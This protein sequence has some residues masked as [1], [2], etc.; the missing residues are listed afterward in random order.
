MRIF[1]SYFP[2]VF[3]SY[4]SLYACTAGSTHHS[5]CS[6]RIYAPTPSHPFLTHGLALPPLRTHFAPRT[7]LFGFGSWHFFHSFRYFIIVFVS[8]F[9]LYLRTSPALH[10]TTPVSSPL[11]H[12]L[13][14]VI[15]MLSARGANGELLFTHRSI[16]SS[17]RGGGHGPTNIGTSAS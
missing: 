9:S 6:Y 12:I 14:K 7:I 2:P 15:P 13:C 5:G 3:V 8:H 11:S 10:Y 4:F 17:R 16:K 1:V